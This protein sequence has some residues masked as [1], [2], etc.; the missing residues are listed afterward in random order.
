MHTKH[1]GTVKQMNGV[2]AG[3]AWAPCA[4]TRDL[5]DL[6]GLPKNLSQY[7]CKPCAVPNWYTTYTTRD[8][9]AEALCGFV[10]PSV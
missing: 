2:S 6:H 5:C 7:P 8:V 9:H 1:V 10:Q 3:P 4:G